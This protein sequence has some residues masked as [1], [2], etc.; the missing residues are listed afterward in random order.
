MLKIKKKSWISSFGGF[1]CY[2]EDKTAFKKNLQTGLKI[3]EKTG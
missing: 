2:L 3:N 1:D